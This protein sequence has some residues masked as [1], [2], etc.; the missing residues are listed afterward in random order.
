MIAAV[1]LAAGE[2]RRMGRPKQLLRVGMSTMVERAV[3]AARGAGIHTVYVVVGHE[4]AA[5]Q[6]SLAHLQVAFVENPN[7]AEG[8]GASVR[9][10]VAAL[11]EAVTAAMFLL[12][13][14]PFVGVELIS[15]L[16]RRSTE[17]NIVA[18]VAA[19]QRGNPT[20]FGR[21][22]FPELLQASGDSGGRTVI[23]AHPEALAF[24]DWPAEDLVDV[25][26][27]E[28]Y[29]AAN[30]GAAPSSSWNSA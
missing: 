26:T 23:H 20:L 9:A 2:S 4:A 10:G 17:S 12:A 11:P 8:I 3:Q 6:A 29:A 22:F 28:D 5:V 15:A 14:Q 18:P 30:S 24:V 21:A 13:D 1:V 16:C 25:D 19:G 7:Y 27:P